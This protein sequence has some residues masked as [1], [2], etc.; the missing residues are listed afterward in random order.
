[1]M[2]KFLAKVN[3]GQKHIA[4]LVRYGRKFKYAQVNESFFDEATEL[5]KQ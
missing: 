1:M 5:S 3:F 4:L 2:F